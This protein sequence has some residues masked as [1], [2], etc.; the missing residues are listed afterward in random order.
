MPK[1]NTGTIIR[2]VAL[3][4][5]LTNQFLAMFGHSPLPFNTEAVEM[6]ASTLFLGIAAI[7]AWWK[8]NDITLTARLRKQAGKK[9]M[10]KH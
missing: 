10:T 5:A 2:S 4:V 3:F 1:V 9:A 7:A 6:F 8:D